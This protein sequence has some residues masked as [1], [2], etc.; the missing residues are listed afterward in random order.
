MNKIKVENNKIITDLDQSLFYDEYK[1][2]IIKNTNVMIDL[3]ET[4]K[5]ITLEIETKENTV[6]SIIILS[7]LTNNYFNYKIKAYSKLNIVHLAVDNTDIINVD[8]KGKEANVNYHYSH[9][10]FKKNQVTFNVNHL[11]DDTESYLVN[12]GVTLTNDKLIFEVNVYV[13][14]NS[15]NC[16]CNQDN[17]IIMLKSNTSSI[18][19]NLLINNQEVEAN[20]SA[21]LG[22]FNKNI[23]FYLESRGISKNKCY[24]LLLKGFLLGE[25]KIDKQLQDWFFHYLNIKKV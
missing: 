20:H 8:L 16:I 19:P 14:D 23:L 10:N 12:H 11:E 24:E 25:V 4:K 9:L 13:A 18:L 21:Y 6:S 2:K 3:S 17:K 1:L 22:S 5:D 7:H 15:K